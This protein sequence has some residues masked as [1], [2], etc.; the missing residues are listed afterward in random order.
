MFH[1]HVCHVRVFVCYLL[2]YFLI[3]KVLEPILG[4]SF[5]AAATLLT[6]RHYYWACFSFRGFVCACA[7]YIAVFLTYTCDLRDFLSTGF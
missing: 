3:F 4:F 7:F 1:L 2:R 5:V 6:P